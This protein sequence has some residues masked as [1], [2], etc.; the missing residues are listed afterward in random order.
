MSLCRHKICL[1]L[2]RWTTERSSVERLSDVQSRW[3]REDLATDIVRNVVLH[4]SHRSTVPQGKRLTS[5]DDAARRRLIVREP[6]PAGDDCNDRVATPRDGSEDR[7]CRLGSYAP[8]SK[9]NQEAD[10]PR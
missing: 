6:S 2:R 5:L 1:F 9:A 4:Q 10:R 7:R 3:R 8:G